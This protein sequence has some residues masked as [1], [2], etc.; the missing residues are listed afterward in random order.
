MLGDQGGIYSFG[1]QTDVFKQRHTLLTL[2]QRLSTEASVELGL[3]CVGQLPGQGGKLSHSLVN[4]LEIGHGVE[5]DAY[6]GTAVGNH[7]EDVGIK[8]GIERRN[9]IL[10]IILAEVDEGRYGFEEMG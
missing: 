6:P 1:E 10:G 5:S 8:A 3:E 9:Y 7:F 4:P 2:R